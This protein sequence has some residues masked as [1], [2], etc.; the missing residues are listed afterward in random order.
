MAEPATKAPEKAQQSGRGSVAL[1]PW[2]PFE[3][4]RREVDRLFDDFGGGAWPRSLFESLPT[5]WRAFGTFPA[6]DIVEKDGSYELT[7]ELPGLGEKDIEVVA[8][9]GILTIKGEKKQETEEKKKGY[10]LSERRYGAFE[11]R[12]PLPEGVDPDR[13]EATFKKGVLTITVP[14]S[15]EA[16][17]AAKRIEVRA[18]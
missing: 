3:T 9:N 8:A 15:A 6:T 14:K 10:Y 1:G 11:R 17:P 2:Q 18:N 7:A 12:F 4:L 5:S 16:Q 13:I